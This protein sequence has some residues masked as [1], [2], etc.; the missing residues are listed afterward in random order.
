L[1]KDFI[2]IETFLKK[3]I[4]ETCMSSSNI[5][6]TCLFFTHKTLSAFKKSERIQIKK[7]KKYKD[8]KK[9]NNVKKI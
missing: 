1:A 7:Y 6:V 9:T 4:N 2:V 3:K 8:N 5:F